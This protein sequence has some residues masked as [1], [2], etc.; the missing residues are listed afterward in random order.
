MICTLCGLAFINKKD[1]YYYDC[2][3]CKAIVKDEK[4]YL[5]VDKEKAIY[6]T[7]NNDVND[8]RYQNFTMPIQCR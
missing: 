3:N 8:I 4:Y 7:H 6:E 5:T 2:D 1:E